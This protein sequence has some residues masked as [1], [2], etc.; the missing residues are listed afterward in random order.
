MDNALKFY[1]K[2]KVG[3]EEN[4]DKEKEPKR[5]QPPCF[6]TSLKTSSTKTSLTCSLTSSEPEGV[7][8]ASSTHLNQHESSP[9][10]ATP[11]LSDSNDVSHGQDDHTSCKKSGVFAKMIK[12]LRSKHK[13]DIGKLAFVDPNQNSAFVVDTSTADK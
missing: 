11:A 9:E 4:E 6:N 8:V 1:D 12:S 7:N 2:L 3:P 10:G 13:E 5:P